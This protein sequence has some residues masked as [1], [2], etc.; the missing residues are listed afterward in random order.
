MKR[1]TILSWSAPKHGQSVSREKCAIS[2]TNLRA[3][4]FQR[5]SACFSV[6]KVRHSIQRGAAHASPKKKLVQFTLYGLLRQISP[7]PTAFTTKISPFLLKMT[8]NCIRG[9]RSAI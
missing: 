8:L 2:L 7:F 6:V 1:E 5:S 9:T 4:V 3:N